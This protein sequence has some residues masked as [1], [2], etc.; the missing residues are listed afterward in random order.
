[1][2]AIVRNDIIVY[3]VYNYVL[4]LKSERK[5]TKVLQLL[6]NLHDPS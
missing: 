5:N 3:N 2:I 6:L 4:L 1:M